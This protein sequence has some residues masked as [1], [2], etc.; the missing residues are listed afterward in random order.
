MNA[1]VCGGKSERSEHFIASLVALSALSLEAGPPG[2][3]WAL[4]RRAPH[5]HLEHSLSHRQSFHAFIL[6]AALAVLHTVAGAAVTC[7]PSAAAPASDASSEPEAIV[8]GVPG[9]IH[10]PKGTRP[11]RA[12]PAAR[13]KESAPDGAPEAP[14]EALP[15]AAVTAPPAAASQRTGAEPG[16]TAQSQQ[17]TVDVRDVYLANTFQRWAKQA[18]WRVR[19]DAA[20]HVMVEAPDTFNGSFEEAVA[21]QIESPGIANS[22]YPLEVCIYPN[23][24]PLVRITRK[25]DQ[26]KECR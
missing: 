20:K 18:G 7:S 13:K 23:N 24:P 6:A 17:W 8:A 10:C 1:I 26:D 11:V 19:W 2:A 9:T 3:F 14:L 4:P 15:V 5:R 21:A 22:S 25:G 12:Q 16:A